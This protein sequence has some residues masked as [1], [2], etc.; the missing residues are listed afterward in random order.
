MSKKKSRPAPTLNPATIM[1]YVRKTLMTILLH[2]CNECVVS[3]QPRA[4]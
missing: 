3:H 2:V 4:S 1:W